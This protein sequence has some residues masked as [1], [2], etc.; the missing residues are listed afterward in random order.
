M[1]EVL[2]DWRKLSLMRDFLL[3]WIQFFSCTWLLLFLRG[4]KA[5]ARQLIPIF[6]NGIKKIFLV[7]KKFFYISN[8]LNLFVIWHI[9]LDA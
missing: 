5:R 4:G 1:K 7:W 8:S 3:L 6:L 9:V 2:F